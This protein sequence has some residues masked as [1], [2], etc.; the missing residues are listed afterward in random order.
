MPRGEMQILKGMGVSSGIAIGRAVCIE[1]RGPDIF[2]LHVP[3]DMV[4][5]EIARLHEGAR[6][7]RSELKRIRAKAE[8]DLGNDLAAIFEAYL[9]QKPDR[10]PD[11][12]RQEIVGQNLVFDFRETAA[13]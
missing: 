1:T 3:E 2:R 13:G 10:L 4:E 11:S 12:V 5:N 9:R 8:E 7:A 6:H